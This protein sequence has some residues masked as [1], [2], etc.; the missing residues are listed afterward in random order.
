MVRI[1]T[2]YSIARRRLKLVD[3]SYIRWFKISQA[4]ANCGHQVDMATN[5]LFGWAFSRSPVQ[6]AD[7]LRRIPLSKVEWSQYDI[8]KTLFHMG[9]DALEAYG[10]ANHPFIISKLGSVVGPKDMRGIYFYGKSRQKLYETQ[11]KIDKTSRYIT[12]LSEPAKRLWMECFGPRDNLLIVPGGVDRDIPSAGQDP[13]PEDKKIRCLFAGNIYHR[14]SQPD[15]N[16][17]LV[18]K[19]NMLGK[20]LSKRGIRLYLLGQ[21][22]TRRLRK[23]YVTYLGSVSYDQAW[24]YFHWAHV[25]VVVSAGEFMHNNESSKIYH[26]LRVGLP[27]VCEAGFPND[28]VVRQSGL[29]FVVENGN[30]DLMAEKI[31]EAS[32]RK[33]DRD[34]AV[35]Y[36]LDNHTWDRRVQ[37]YDRLIRQNFG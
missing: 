10:A 22:Y 9:F 23:Q 13:Y 28:D 33:W 24:A 36:I 5:D 4:L 16:A 8:V 29:G 11:K 19:L 37:I 25:G 31:M 6:I 12:V 26:Y 35:R 21:G 2:V 3:M 14:K 17:I 7:N 34:F 30:L 27:V 15:A 32:S 20:R 1:V 18:E